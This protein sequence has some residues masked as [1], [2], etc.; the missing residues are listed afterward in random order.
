M[1]DSLGSVMAFEV[2]Q[3]TGKSES[4]M[5]NVT[6]VAM[7]QTKFHRWIEGQMLDAFKSARKDV[8]RRPGV[9]LRSPSG[10]DTPKLDA[11]KIASSTIMAAVTDSER[12]GANSFADYCS[13]ADQQ[14]VKSSEPTRCLVEWGLDGPAKII[15][16]R[17]AHA[18]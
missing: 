15:Q 6:E 7:G 14:I 10:S 13:S 5:T 3:W 2:S 12:E 9:N 1:I 8:S 11:L 16:V 18:L 4:L 17:G